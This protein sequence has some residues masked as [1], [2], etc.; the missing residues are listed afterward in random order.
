MRNFRTLLSESQFEALNEIFRNF[1]DQ[2]SVV[3]ELDVLHQQF[4]KQLKQT[5]TEKVNQGLCVLET[6]CAMVVREKRKGISAAA[7]N[8][9]DSADYSFLNEFVLRNY[10]LQ[11]MGSVCHHDEVLGRAQTILQKQLQKVAEC[12]SALDLEVP[13]E[14]FHQLRIALKN[15]RYTISDFSCLRDD[16]YSQ[17]LSRMELLQN[18][19]GQ[20]HDHQM[21]ITQSREILAFIGENGGEETE[22][23]NSAACAV[24]LLARGWQR[25]VESDYSDVRKIWELLDRD[26]FWSTFDIVESGSDQRGDPF[27]S[28]SENEHFEDFT[29]STPE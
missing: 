25:Q 7:R 21:W 8:I 20:I 23:W 15:L 14:A 17:Q 6:A 3:R 28:E 19:M 1:A 11:Q 2:L 16:E 12:A 18:L 10:D 24:S 27:T 22:D 29:E 4:K 9:S 5:Y 26:A 13:D